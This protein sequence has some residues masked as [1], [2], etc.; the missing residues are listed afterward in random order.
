MNLYKLYSVSLALISAVALIIGSEFLGIPDNLRVALFVLIL[1]GLI[2]FSV[3]AVYEGQIETLLSHAAG[4]IGI[5]AVVGIVSY[6]G[7]ARFL[8]LLGLVGVIG[9]IGYC[10]YNPCTRAI[11]RLT[12]RS[13]FRF[14]FFWA[15]AALLVLSVIGLPLM[16][17]GDGTSEGMAQILINYT[18][19][20][21]FFILGAGTLWFAAGSMAGDIEDAQIQMIATKPVARWQIWLGKWIGIMGL[22]VML[23]ALVYVAVYGMVKYKGHEMTSNRLEELKV[24]V[25]WDDQNQSTQDRDNKIFRMALTRNLEVFERDEEGNM[26]PAGED[27]GERSRLE[28]SY[29][30]IVMQRPDVAR[31]ITRFMDQQRSTNARPKLK[32]SETLLSEIASIQENKMRKQVLVGRDEFKL[33]DV[34]YVLGQNDPIVPLEENID[35]EGMKAAINK[36]IQSE[37]AEL[38]RM[39]QSM[40]SKGGGFEIPQELTAAQLEVIT[41]RVQMSF[42]LATQSIEPSRGLQFQFAKPRGFRLGEE[43]RLNLQFSFED[44]TLGSGNS[45]LHRFWFMY[46][47][48]DNDRIHQTG[49]FLSAAK[50]HELSLEAREYDANTNLV[51]ILA[52]NDMFNLTVIN[53]PTPPDGSRLKIPFLNDFTGEINDENVKIMYIESG[54]IVNFLRACGIL[55]AW[56]GLL[57][58]LGL[59]AACFMSF[60]VSAFACIVVLFMATW[61][62]EKM[63]IVIQDETIMT[64]Y[65]ME[66]ERQKS[67]L[68]WFALPMFKLASPILEAQRAYSPISDLSEGRSITWDELLKA[69]SY[70]WGIFGWLIGGFGTIIFTQRQLSITSSQT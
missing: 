35:V 51:S 44:P 12:W 36:E 4:V 28:S 22:N 52:T 70:T 50:Q 2:L 40:A 53:F 15:M 38:Q 67:F 61:G 59:S 18:L 64:T 3:L 58:A 49:T 69:Y 55:L 43:G 37:L 33:K 62:A 34:K 17:K 16:V 1:V 57:A 24:E 14:R 56:L 47:N 20:F 41:N 45:K 9:L 30:A 8:G 23:L 21:S 39:G 46:G 54:F 60:E 26:I 5:V 13:A 29:D 19:N 27:L 6:I 66:G 11:S 25:R 42:R 32:S 7:G 68:D 31:H 48:E 10:I 63:K 65:T